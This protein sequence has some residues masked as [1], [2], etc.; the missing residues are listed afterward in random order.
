MS[1]PAAHPADSDIANLSF[2]DALAELETIVRQLE[3]GD[4]PLDRSVELFARG[5]AL[6]AQ[7]EKLLKAAEMRIQQVRAD[8]EGT[9][10]GATPFDPA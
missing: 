9:A 8:S 1:T 10:T 7:C 2:E 3:S 4:A 5:D 6:R